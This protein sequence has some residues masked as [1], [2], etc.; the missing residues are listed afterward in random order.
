MLA[1]NVKSIVKMPRGRPS[2]ARRL[3]AAHCQFGANPSTCNCGPCVGKL[4]SQQGLR[5]SYKTSNNPQDAAK[6]SAAPTTLLVNQSPK[7]M[8]ATD[9][10]PLSRWDRATRS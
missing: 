7:I 4:L 8:A 2:H 10:G 6:H 9:N 1:L 5:R 3:S